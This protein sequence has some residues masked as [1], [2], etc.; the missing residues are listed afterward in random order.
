[1]ELTICRR[2]LD[3]IHKADNP[4]S[5]R[6][7]AT[8]QK[9]HI[10]MKILKSLIR[11]ALNCLGLE[12]SK[13]YPE[14]QAI[15]EA[16]KHFNNKSIIACEIGIYDGEHALEMFKHLNISKF[17]LIDPYTKYDYVDD[18]LYKR[19][20]KA[21]K[22]AHQLLAPYQDKIVW[23]EEYSDN[24]L[25]HIKEPLDMVYIDGNHYS[26]YVDNDIENYYKIVAEGGVI[27]GHDY[28]WI[29][30]PDV[31][32]AVHAFII[33]ENKKLIFGRGLDWVVFR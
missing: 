10:T 30:W 13:I 26:P 17:Y 23:I 19:L 7:P 31:A 5:N 15:I 22:N 3:Q 12:V 20:Q 8:L 25:P 28:S 6:K 33:R 4:R 18:N 1:M 27:S 24:A 21:K 16:K 2:P 14:R 29:G 9:K 11:K 32:N